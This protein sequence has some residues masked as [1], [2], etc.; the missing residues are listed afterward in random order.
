[1]IIFTLA[2]AV[3]LYI[4]GFFLGRKYEKDEMMDEVVGVLAE[5]NKTTNQVETV[6]YYYSEKAYNDKIKY[7]KEVGEEYYE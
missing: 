5:I 6:T 7:L 3:L 1:M 2:G 4:I